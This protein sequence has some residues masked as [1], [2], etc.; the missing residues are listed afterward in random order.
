M[1]ITVH[2]AK[3]GAEF[4]V[5]IAAIATLQEDGK[6]RAMVTMTNGT[7]HTLLESR[8]QVRELARGARELPEEDKK[9]L[10]KAIAEAKPRPAKPAPATR[11]KPTVAVARL[12]S[13][14]TPTP[15]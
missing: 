14:P 3:N 15:R 1:L 7:A 6:G 8:A 10:A 11:G 13:G 9:A 12:G 2:N 4:E 5:G